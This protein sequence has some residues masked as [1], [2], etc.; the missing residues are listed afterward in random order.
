MKKLFLGMMLLVGLGTSQVNAQEVSYGVKVE[1]NMSNYLMSK[2]DGAQSRMKLGASVGGFAKIDFSEH[3]A[4]QPELLFHYQS[5]SLKYEGLKRNFNYWG[6][7]IPIYAVGQMTLGSGDRIYAGVG[8]YIGYGF[9]NKLN[10]PSTKMYKDDLMH[11]FDFGAKVMIG[12]EFTNRIQVNASYKIGFLNEKD[13]GSGR[14]NT[15][16][17]SLGVGYRF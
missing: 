5:S 1:A 11:R 8:P 13:K 6:A 2:M 10:K 16:A 4:I 14:M 9:S 17:L 15:E 3:F 7:E 12:Y